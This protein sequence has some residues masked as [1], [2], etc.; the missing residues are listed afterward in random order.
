MESTI[1]IRPFFQDRWIFAY[2]W[3]SDWHNFGYGLR[4]VAKLHFLEV[5]ISYW[6]T[7]TFL[8]IGPAGYFIW[9]W[10]VCKPCS[11][12]QNLVV[13]Y[14]LVVFYPQQCHIEISVDQWYVI[15]IAI[16]IMLLFAFSCAELLI[17]SKG[18]LSV[19]MT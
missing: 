8:S 19:R 2:F 11:I 15:I 17:F 7:P 1:R 6:N 18:G 5:H 12:V 4:K 14:H 10:K 13:T 9:S 3:H 16:R